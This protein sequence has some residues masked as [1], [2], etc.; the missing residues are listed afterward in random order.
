YVASNNNYDLNYINSHT[1]N[2][3]RALAFIGEPEN[4]WGLVAGGGSLFTSSAT[5]GA[6]LTSLGLSLGANGGV[7]ALNGNI[8]DKFDYVSF[9]TSGFTGIGGAGKSLHSNLQLNV[10]GAYFSSQVTGQN[11]EAAMV[12]AAAGTGIGYAVGSRITSRLEAKAIKDYFGMPASS[13]A[14][15]YTE[16]AFGPGYL[17]K[18]GKMSPVPGIVGGFIGS[19]GAEVSNSSIQADINKDKK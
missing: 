3:D 17:L 12:G 5:T 16:K 4:F 11:S 14:L 10:G 8:G 15:K 1:T 13:N 18:G 9:F 7:Q 19:G 2:G 6:K